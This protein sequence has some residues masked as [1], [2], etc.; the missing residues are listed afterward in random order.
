MSPAQS[1]DVSPTWW[2][3]NKDDPPLEA[4]SER[5]EI[6]VASLISL[7]AKPGQ[8]VPAAP[9]RRSH[10]TRVIAVG[11]L[12]G[13]VLGFVVAI[14]MT[15]VPGGGEAV[16][17]GWYGT[18]V[19]TLITIKLLLSM[20]AV[21][22]PIDEKSAAVLARYDVSA[23]ITC[24][25]ED[26][27]TFARCLSSILNSTRLPNSLTII[28]DG[29]TSPACF[30][31]ARSL[32]PSFRAAGV[33][34]DIIVFAKNR[35]KRAGLA[36]GFRRTW[37]ADV[38]LCIDSDTILHPEAIANGLRPFRKRRVQATTGAVF[39]ANRGRNILT[40]LIDLRYC[41]AFLGERAAYSV[42]GSVLCCCG[43]LAFYRGVTV[44]KYLKNFL[45]QRFLGRQC[46]YGDDRR[47][48]YYC[49]REGRVVLA[50]SAIAWT[51]VPTTMKHFLRQQLRWSKSF[52]RESLWMITTVPPWRVCWW[53]TLVEIATGSGLTTALIY[54]IAV[55]P[56]VSGHFEG[57][58]Y[59]TSIL[60]LSYARSGHY[61]E[62]Q[63]PDVRLPGKLMTF[64]IAPLYGIIHMTLLLPLRVVAL[65]TLRDNGWGTRKSVEVRS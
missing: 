64:A 23:I 29:S 57:L 60:I 42:L 30:N 32:L 55:R 61:I 18:S 51:L 54:T 50:P 63:H 17:L 34:Y 27:G 11:L 41:Y 37:H 56:A 31:I 19:L 49:L 6:A 44:R 53:L 35:G 15:Q 9:T 1:S 21:P 2:R 36:A 4:L 16:H 39:A 62:A 22:D 47:L 33:D 48:T 10:K 7:A 24:M 28:D 38:Y 12:T 26:P 46:T 43:S 13:S 8:A 65:L 5:Q 45:N 58:S 3:P 20:L 25:N 14:H 59:L 40:R 52:F